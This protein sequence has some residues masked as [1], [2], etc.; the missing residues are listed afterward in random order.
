MSSSTSSSNHRRFFLWVVLGVVASNLAVHLIP[1]GGISDSKRAHQQR[2]RELAGATDFLIVGDSKAGPFSVGCLLPWFAGYRGL[3]FSGDSVT[4]VFHYNNLVEIRAAVPEFRPRVVFIFVGANNFNTNGQHVEREYTFFS[5]LELRKAW[6]WSAAQGDLLSF[7]EALLSRVFPLYG[8][9]VMITHLEFHQS[10]DGCSSTDSDSYERAR[11]LPLESTPRNPIYDKN[12]YDIYRRSLY[13]SYESSP[14]IARAT[15][16]LIELVRSFG[17]VPVLVLP[18][19][20]P[21][22]RALEHEM[23]GD[24]FD[25]TLKAIVDKERVRL[26]DLRD[27]HD[28]EFSDVNHLTQRGAR[29]VAVDYFLPILEEHPAMTRAAS[30]APG[31]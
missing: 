26:L 20:T 8:R 7:V 15:E 18:P 9:R 23:I 28:Y 1:W 30:A 12:Y 27:Q 31:R 4:P 24:A 5:E 29:D 16:E 10:K 3:T 25:E 6:E 13:S 19:V 2:A 21:E 11:N 14:I 22:I 17:G